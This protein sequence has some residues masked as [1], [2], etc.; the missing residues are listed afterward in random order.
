MD[1]DLTQEI[2]VT[3]SRTLRFLSLT[4]LLA[5]CAV[6]CLSCFSSGGPPETSDR[7]AAG[8]Q[9]RPQRLEDGGSRPLT[10]TIRWATASEVANFG[11][12]VYR[13][14]SEDGPFE[15]VNQEIIEGAGTTDEPQRYE[16]VDTTVE[17]GTA[18]F[19]YVESIS[20]SGKREQFTPVRKAPPKSAP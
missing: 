18:Y 15:R 12:D 16:F 13:S 20:L 19:Y 11:F 7:P 5:V 10:N 2:L 17:P 14:V 8:D 6:L 9:Q 3:S 1:V 4:A